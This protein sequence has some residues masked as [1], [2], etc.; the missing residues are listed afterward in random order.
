MMRRLAGTRRHA[1]GRRGVR[2]PAQ[3]RHP[4]RVP[5]RPGPSRHRCAAAAL[6]DAW[7]SMARAHAVQSRRRTSEAPREALVSEPPGAS[8][9]PWFASGR[10]HTGD[11]SRGSMC[12]A[13]LAA[14]RCA[15]WPE[16]TLCE[17]GG[18]PARTA[19]GPSRARPV[20]ARPAPRQ[21]SARRP[22]TRRACESSA[23]RLRSHPT[24]EPMSGASCACARLAGGVG[25]TLGGLEAAISTSERS[26]LATLIVGLRCAR[27][28]RLSWPEARQVAR[29][30]PA[31]GWACP[32]MLLGRPL[33]Q[34]AANRARTQQQSP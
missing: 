21:P 26:T 32:A 10:T 34:R 2:S 6:C 17:A 28:S 4:R 19:G 7:C 24:V 23:E 16:R 33:P 31:D 18:G 20:H 11:G 30:R 27:E 12:V 3:P 13:E 15:A 14:E 9:G 5:A 22:A 25:R 1:A 8:I 29:R